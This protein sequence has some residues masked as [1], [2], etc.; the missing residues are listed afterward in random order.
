MASEVPLR[1]PTKRLGT[2]LI[3]AGL[4]SEGQLKDALQKKEAEGGFIGKI[5]AEMNFIKEPTLIS[6]LVK[7]CKIPHIN[8]IEYEIRTELFELVSKE[9]CVKYD[10]LPIDKL[11]TILTLAMVDPL[12]VA[13][14]DEVRS[15]CPDLRIKPILCSWN[16]FR[17]VMQR[18]FPDTTPVA[19]GASM[20]DFGL[21]NAPKSPPKKKALQPNKAAS[22]QA[23][24]DIDIPDAIVTESLGGKASDATQA[25][26]LTA[27]A[28]IRDAV[29]FGMAGI[30]KR[31]RDE[32]AAS[33]EGLA[34]TGEQFVLAVEEAVEDAVQEGVSSLLNEMEDALSQS[35]QL[36]SDLTTEELATVIR[37]NVKEGIRQASSDTVTNLTRLFVPAGDPP[38]QK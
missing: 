22:S 34:L 20:D 38:Q 18:L 25:F 15:A 31:V 19:Q 35:T 24:S 2:M 6:F 30:Q 8:L 37:T 36:A 5:L 4:I 9:L 27:Q 7:Q 28:R 32:I 14:L 29:R 17:Q 12:D 13:A 33:R 16:Q 3:E 1:A 23:S 11:G 10:L 21:S 26:L